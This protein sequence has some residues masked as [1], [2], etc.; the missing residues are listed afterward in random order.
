[1]D[2]AAACRAWSGE[3]APAATGAVGGLS[4]AAFPYNS[5]HMQRESAVTLLGMKR[6]GREGVLMLVRW[7]VMAR[8]A[9]RLPG[10]YAA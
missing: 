1:M 9:Q 10:N 2:P 7:D 8:Y 6:L 4:L 5:E 3:Q